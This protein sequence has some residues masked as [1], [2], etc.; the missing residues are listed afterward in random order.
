MKFHTIYP[1]CYRIGAFVH[2]FAHSIET[3][4]SPVI[5]ATFTFVNERGCV[6]D[7][8]ISG[9]FLY[10]RKVICFWSGHFGQCNNAPVLNG[11]YSLSQW[12]SGD[13]TG[14]DTG[15]DEIKSLNA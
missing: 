7:N 1:F 13:D 4:S 10:A 9:G 5:I 12:N 8:T 14:D 6:C 15:D 3:P 11:Q 2:V